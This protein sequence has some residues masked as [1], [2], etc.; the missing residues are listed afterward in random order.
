MLMPLSRI[1]V[2]L[3]AL[4]LAAPAAAEGGQDP[5]FR[6][7]VL[8]FA[9]NSEGAGSSES[10]PGNPGTPDWSRAQPLQPGLTQGMYGM[11]Q[12]G[13]PA[14]GSDS[15]PTL[16]PYRLLP[17]GRLQLTQPANYLARTGGR[18]ETL[19]HLAWQQ[20]VSSKQQAQWLYLRTPATVAAAPRLEGMLLIS[21]SRYLHIDLDLLL[22]KPAAPGAA[23]A[24]D[25]SL[26]SPRYRGYRFQAH[27][28]MRSGEI[29][30]IDHPLMG[31]LVQITPVEKPSDAPSPSSWD[32]PQTGVTPVEEQEQESAAEGLQPE[33]AAANPQ[34]T[35]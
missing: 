24:S 35:D 15:M 9:R 16:A 6:I 5:W 13:Q 18:L 3:Y 20:P 2:L 25:M 12:G 10:W 14:T 1:T 4:F 30:Y 19:L 22:R 11:E 8:V 23:T 31:A 27:R 21:L 7:E 34:E 17:E 26:L 32:K 29:H 33:S 28:R